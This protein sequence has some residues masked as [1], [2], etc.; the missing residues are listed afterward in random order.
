M[1][2]TSLAAL[3]AIPGTR[4]GQ[5]GQVTA[6]S[7]KGEYVWSGSAWVRTGDLIDG[8]TVTAI[9]VKADATEARLAQTA[10]Q[11]GEIIVDGST[12]LFPQSWFWSATD[13]AAASPSD[14]S[15]FWEASLSMSLTAV[16]FYYLDL[17]LLGTS[18]PIRSV[19]GSGSPA[20][21]AA[22]LILLGYSIGG[23][24]SA[25][26]GYPVAGDAPGGASR[27]LCQAGRYPARC[28]W[29]FEPGAG[30]SPVA[31]AAPSGL[32]ALGF[33]Q[34]LV[35]SGNPQLFYGDDLP[36]PTSGGESFM[37]RFWVYSPTSQYGTPEAYVWTGF[38]AVPIT[39]TVY[40]EKRISSTIAMV[41]IRGKIPDG[42]VA[43][44]FLVGT[45]Q[46]AARD[47]QITGVQFALG[48]TVRWI[49]RGDFCADPGDDVPALGPKLYMVAGRP[50]PIYLRNLVRQRDD[51]DRQMG[52]FFSMGS[53]LL[54][55]APEGRDVLLI[56]PD[57]CGATGRLELRGMG[58]GNRPGR[59]LRADLAISVKSLPLS[60]SPRILMFGN[61]LINRRTGV[62]LSARLTAWGLTPVFIGTIA[63]ADTEIATSSGGPL[64]E[65]REGY[66]F[67]DFIYKRI[68]GETAPV[69]DW[70]AYLA[71]GKST[72]LPLNPSF[73]RRRR[74][75]PMQ[76]D[77]SNT[78]AT[79]FP[80]RPIRRRRGLRPRTSSSSS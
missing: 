28:G 46:G 75:R 23:I 2:A 5:P 16:R 39:T 64:G 66:A 20:I 10:L 80:R 70:S 48:R 33:P 42:T 56:D 53:N 7:D 9:S 51:A 65:C 47:A 67:A 40:L 68:D 36:E 55:H 78:T 62:K 17:S 74:A 18:N 11:R 22:G 72:R 34:V 73:G 77:G 61:S 71:G 43:Q 41:M 13:K 35:N 3:N 50:M 29:V 37:A 52:A 30:P 8:A 69:T 63:G 6:T 44:R 21:D 38:A 31:Q 12:V 59:R 54:P 58:S 45:N 32:V 14:G 60:G 25:A 79:P 49:M 19:D 15:L 27:N 24:F 1:R 4:A 76:P 26:R 57:K